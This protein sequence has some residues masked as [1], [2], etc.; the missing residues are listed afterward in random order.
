MLAVCGQDNLGDKPRATA[1]YR[2]MHITN[3]DGV[4]V[5]SMS[6]GTGSHSCS[7]VAGQ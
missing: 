3:L 4:N 1:C 7:V 6:S 5:V 2:D